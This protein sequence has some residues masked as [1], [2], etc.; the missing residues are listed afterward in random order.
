MESSA[1]TTRLST[2]CLIS[3]L[4]TWAIT[5]SRGWKTIVLAPVLAHVADH[6]DHPLDQAGQVGPLALDV[7]AAGE[8][9]QLLGDALAAERLLLDH[10]QVVAR[11]PWRR[12]RRE[13]ARGSRPSRFS[14]ASEQKAI[15][16]SGLLI[17]WAT[18]AARKP[19]PASRSERTSCRLRSWTWLLEVGVGDAEPARSCR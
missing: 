13:L 5:A 9:E 3:W 17:S 11:R 16:A 2:T 15:E 18:P 19:T 8:V 12:R 1:L 10:P 7:G 14:S 6:L 4:S